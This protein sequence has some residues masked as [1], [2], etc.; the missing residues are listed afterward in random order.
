M[1]KYVFLF[2]TFLEALLRW[3]CVTSFGG[4][5]HFKLSAW[6]TFTQMNISFLYYNRKIMSVVMIVQF[7]T[8]GYSVSSDV[9][10]NSTLILLFVTIYAWDSYSPTLKSSF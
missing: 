10:I 9:S 5:D 4:Q 7:S 1:N 6:Q 8:V 3:V 2:L